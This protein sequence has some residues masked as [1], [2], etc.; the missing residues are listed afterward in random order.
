MVH[1]ALTLT[2]FS[3]ST[4]DWLGFGVFVVGPTPVDSALAPCPRGNGTA[5]RTRPWVGT[6]RDVWHG[7]FQCL[8]CIAAT[9]THRFKGNAERDEASFDKG[10]KL[11][12]YEERKGWYRGYVLPA[13][14]HG[15]IPGNHLQITATH[16]ALDILA[17]GEEPPPPVKKGP[18]SGGKKSA[19]DDAGAM[20]MSLVDIEKMMTVVDEAD[21]DVPVARPSAGAGRGKGKQMQAAPGLGSKKEP[22]KKSFGDDDG[23]DE[24]LG[25][26]EPKASPVTKKPDIP[27]KPTAVPAKATV[28]ADKGRGAP[29]K[30]RH[31]SVQTRAMLTRALKRNR[32]PR[33]RRSTIC[34]HSSPMTSLWP[35]PLRAA[36]RVLTPVVHQR[37]SR[38]ARAATMSTL[39]TMVRRQKANLARASMPLTTTTMTMAE[40]RVITR[41]RPRKAL[42]PCRRPRGVPRR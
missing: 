14:T 18:V 23:F 34:C 21:E 27:A 37:R 5:L 8:L 29:G 6:A 31:G 41:R 2:V 30:L 1:N 4:A 17:P 36:R 35:S 39:M 42:W 3:P 25:Q 9:A 12:L 10:A 40:T 38:W 16:D 19:A 15:L 20:Q 24:L 13:R 22:L 11:E 32:R 33:R 28:A 7:V 26:M